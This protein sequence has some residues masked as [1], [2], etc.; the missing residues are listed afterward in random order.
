MALAAPS[1]KRGITARV[2][3]RFRGWFGPGEPMAPLAPVGTD[4]RQF[5]YP[6]STNL[7]VRP[8]VT[9]SIDFPTL[10]GLSNDTLTRAAIETCK[11]QFA[12]LTYEV[13]PRD[14]GMAPPTA[15]RLAEIT[16]FLRFP[17]QRHPFT[18]WLR[19]LLEDML[20]IDAPAVYI[21]RDRSGRPIM[22]EV[23]DGATLQPIVD[24]TG[25]TPLDGGPI[26]RQIVKGMPA[27]DFTAD[28]LVVMPRN[29]RSHK[30]HGFS[31]VEQCLLFINIS[32]RREIS[33]LE[34]FT[35][36]NI[37]DVLVPVPEG[38][39]KDQIVSAQIYWDSLRG[40]TARRRGIT[41]I[42]TKD[43]H[44]TRLA[45]IKD[46]FDEWRARVV[47]F[48][49]SLPAT[50]AVKMMNR[51]TSET[52]QSTAVEEGLLPRMLWAATFMDRLIEVSWGA[53]INAAFVWQSFKDPDPKI[54]ADVGEIDIRN[55]V[56]SPNEVRAE[57]GLDPVEGGDDPFVMTGTGP[58][59]LKDIAAGLYRPV[60]PTVQAQIDAD[61]KAAFQAKP[62]QI[63]DGTT[64][65]PDEAAPDAAALSAAIAAADETAMAQ[66]A[67][68][69]RK[70]VAGLSRRKRSFWQAERALVLPRARPNANSRGMS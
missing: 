12:R 29:P 4:P 18:S 53:D 43:V 61:A 49:F 10:R 59:L 50:W 5:D 27:V 34:Y 41:L 13:H 62:L 56:R 42:P 23:I 69:R 58:I 64:T 2:G 39:T 65:T 3:E 67:G 28:E 16:A 8:R 55:G 37:P 25:R 6:V 22:W 1:P 40:D 44:E 47:M 68:P 33:Q 19:M 63:E 9:E 54:M 15:A 26:Y 45:P 35:E 70:T 20:V 48:F 7:Q 57:R 52:A 36:G 14:G 60:D 32:L 38:W 24:A 17:D 21:R 30:L 66:A 31:P 51:A 11:D 46:E